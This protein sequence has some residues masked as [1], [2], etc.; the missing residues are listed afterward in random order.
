MIRLYISVNRM[1]F[2][3]EMQRLKMN[4][5]MNNND[6]QSQKSRRSINPSGISNDKI[7][8]LKCRIM[9]DIN[10]KQKQKEHVSLNNSNGVSANLKINRNVKMNMND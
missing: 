3:K 6:S 9:T 4:L 2:N 10:Q 1:I 8:Q 5:I 7:Q